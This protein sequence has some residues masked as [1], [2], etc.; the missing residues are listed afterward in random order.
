LKIYIDL[1]IKSLDSK[2]AEILRKLGYKA[3]AVEEER[4]CVADLLVITK[5]VIE[6]NTRKEIKEKLHGI[7]RKHVLVSVKPLSIE[8]ARMAAHD[9]R[10][11]TIIIDDTCYKYIDRNQINL[12]KQ[13]SK[14]LELP[15]GRW[16]AYTPRK[17]SAIY[18]RVMYYLFHTK[19]PLI[20]TSCAKNWNEL[21][22]PRSTIYLLSIAFHI[23]LSQAVLSLTSYPRELISRCGV[24][25]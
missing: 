23:P 13:H 8:A 24:S 19:M 20:V 12:M 25:I 16:L 6:A 15:L 4:E 5:R 18:R 9:S 7:K 22:V 3:I 2:T 14:P 1:W 11:D 10:V 21:L 17:R